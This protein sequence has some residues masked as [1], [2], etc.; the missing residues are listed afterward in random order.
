M[1]LMAYFLLIL[2]P[3]HEWPAMFGPFEYEE[4]R[5]VFEFIDRQN[6]ESSGCVLLPLPQED[7]VYVTVPFIP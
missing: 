4:C 3:E 7:A 1:P 6:L 2:L 5:A